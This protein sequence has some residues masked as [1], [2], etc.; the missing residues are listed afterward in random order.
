MECRGN[1]S[2]LGSGTHPDASQILTI[3][4][5]FEPGGS[6]QLAHLSSLHLRHLLKIHGLHGLSFYYPMLKLQQYGNLLLEIDKAIIRENRENMTNAELLDNCFLRGLNPDDL[7]RD[8]MLDYIERWL[9][10]SE[11]L[12]KDSISLLLHL[13]IFIGYNSANRFWASH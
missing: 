10:V 3:K 4:S 7:T 8:E 12:D 2:R 6:Y 9:A 13:P 5:C 1:F 11:H